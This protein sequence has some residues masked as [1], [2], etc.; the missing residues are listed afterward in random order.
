[1]HQ[2]L[3]SLLPTSLCRCLLCRCLL[4]ESYNRDACPLSVSP[5]VF[6][7]LAGGGVSLPPRAGSV[8]HD[9]GKSLDDFGSSY[10]EGRICPG[11][12]GIPARRYRGAGSRRERRMSESPAGAEGGEVCIRCPGRLCLESRSQRLRIHGDCG[13]WGLGNGCLCLIGRIKGTHY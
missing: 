3:L 12:L 13:K 7:K 1:M 8:R 4:S 5:P 10:H 2:I 9:R 11:G 6:K